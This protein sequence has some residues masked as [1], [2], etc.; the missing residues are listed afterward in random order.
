MTTENHTKRRVEYR[1]ITC[2]CGV[3]F[4]PKSSRQKH[5]SP[6]CR[7]IAIAEPFRSIDGCWHWPKGFFTAT[8]YGQF[9][10][11]A[12][13]PEA[14]HRMSY[15]VFVG[16]VPDGKYVCHRCDNRACFNPKHLFVGEPVENVEDMWRK[17][18][19][20]DYKRHVSGPAHHSYGKPF[21]KNQHLRTT[22]S[23]SEKNEIIARAQTK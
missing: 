1:A 12:N 20:Q 15:R 18:R 14:A 4:I 7:F 9:A 6:A 13:V 8:G 5:C 21:G 19:Q 23:S 16:P 10:E 11:S 3:P 17:G 2:D 22:K